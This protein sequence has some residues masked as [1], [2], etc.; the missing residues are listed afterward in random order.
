MP[1][2]A[3]SPLVI[4]I[5]T[6]DD[7]V[8]VRQFVRAEATACGFS[9]VDLTKLVTAASELGRNALKYGGGGE[10][11]ATRLNTGNRSG[12]QLIFTDRGPGIPDIDEAMRD[13][14]T[15][16]NGLGLGL[17]GTRRLVNQFEIESTPGEGTAV[18]IIKWK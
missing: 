12:I 17:G 4:P 1:E 8:R 7:V 9:L 10:M 11:S 13:G 18:T 6:Q 2:A 3:A 5:R 15:T 16:G 14:Y